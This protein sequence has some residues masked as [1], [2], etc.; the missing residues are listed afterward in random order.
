MSDYAIE[1]D[2]ISKIYKL[3]G[4][5]KHRLKEALHPFKKKYH[6]DFYALRDVSFK[7]K[8][9]TTVGFI[10]ENGSGKSTLLK[11]LTGIIPAS[12]GNVKVNGKIS[13][14]LEL[15]TGFNPE[16]TGLENIYFNGTIL[17]FTKKEMDEK[18]DEIIAFSEIGDFI[19]QPVKTYSSG[20]FVRLAFSVAINVDP[21]I[22]I[23][24][25][26]LSVGDAYFS[27]KCMS[28]MKEFKESGKT[29]LF[30]SHDPV[31]VKTLCGEAY[32]L[33]HGK[34]IDSGSPDRVFDYYNSLIS[35]KKEE[36]HLI[37]KEILRDRSGNKKIEILDVR[38]LDDNGNESDSFIS[39]K[40]LNINMR[41]KANESVQEPTFGIA[42]KD[43]FGNDIFGIN[44]NC[45]DIQLGLFQQ[46]SISNINFSMVLNLGANIYNLT[47]AAHSGNTHLEDNFDWIN[48][49]TTFKVIPNTDFNFT[50][51]S[52]LY[53]QITRT[54][55]M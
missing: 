7:I 16:L 35:L 53:P 1:I 21:D 36:R 19:H 54:R 9:G 32:L 10:G 6:K 4:D 55:I 47:I 24:D 17:G 29:I 3:Y 52:K 45:L 43:R 49:A 11:I 8:K 14:L 38:L 44:N 26:A 41:V 39:G 46:G 42:I 51:Y 37:E 25:E 18:R 20:M 27:V 30:V 50:G 23:I 12:S 5:N 2:N 28:R 13:A 40:K 48:N 33:E 34:V 15:G 22:L 31:A